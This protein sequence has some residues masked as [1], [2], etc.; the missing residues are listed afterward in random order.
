MGKLSKFILLLLFVFVMTLIVGC[1][2]G[3][4]KNDD[5]NSSNSSDETNA[6]EDA[7]S[8]GDIEEEKDPFGKYDPPIDV[9]F[10]RY[11]E[12]TMEIALVGDET[13]EDNRWL[14]YYR[15]ELGINITYDW[16]TSGGDQY[17]QKLNVSLASG[18]IP[19][20]VAVNTTQLNQLVEADMIMEVTDLYEDYAAP[21]TKEMLSID[22][23]APFDAATIDGKLW[24]LPNVDASID[25]AHFVW[26]RTDWLEKLNL[27]EPKTMDDLLAISEAFVT[28]DPDGNGKDDTTGLA[29]T[30]DLWDGYAGLIGFFNGFHAYPNI[31]IKDESGDLVF[32]SVQPEAKEA[33]QALQDMFKAGQID[34]EFG[35]KPGGTVMED[36]AGGK[37]GMHFGQQWTSLWPLQS[38]RDNDPNAQWKSFAL[39][40][41]DDQ[42]ARPQIS[43]GTDSWWVVRKDVEQP[44]AIVKM[45][46][47]F[48]EKNWGAT[49]EFDRYYMPDGAEGTWKLS[50]PTPTPPTKNLDAFLAIREAVENDTTDQL[51]GEAKVVYGRVKAHEDG[52]E[53]L[54][55]WERIYGAD[56]VFGI[57]KEYVDQDLFIRNEFNGAPTPTMVEKDATLTQ[58]QDEAFTKIILGD[59][60]ID[61]FD[62]FVEDW[63]KLGGKEIT[64]EVNEWYQSVN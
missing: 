42:P 34:K 36:P 52:D 17:D 55:G 53:S 23:T 37:N 44:E 12:E 39:V 50:P 35:V 29:I 21:F 11:V 32:G 33:L 19:H 46:N 7:T 38:S 60:D 54:W 20:F 2:D 62:T 51:E 61:E 22:G 1:S 31:W 8:D 30:K 48:M 49:A 43:S 5:V 14:D 10:V 56:G 45:F 25:G 41:V 58:L 57:M 26:V 9:S 13:I 28:Q 4:N 3:D 40:S 18:D 64:Q 6:Q 27:P 16:I 15:D 24:G 47:G 63:E 59:A